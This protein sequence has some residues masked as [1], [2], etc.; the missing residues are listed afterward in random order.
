LHK[1][2]SYLTFFVPASVD[3]V[4]EYLLFRLI[5]T[6]KTI[7]TVTEP[8]QFPAFWT[9]EW[10]ETAISE[11]DTRAMSPEKRMVY[12]M[13]ISANATAVNN[14]QKKIDEAEKRA[15]DEVQT[16]TVQKLLALKSLTVEQ[17]ADSTGV[18]VDFVL[19]IQQKHTGGQ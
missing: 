18:S 19:D 8:T 2:D 4:N 7:D 11:L 5:Y 9:E 17:I 16:N 1:S 10:L 12:E 14:E 15:K 13:T 3:G 6:M